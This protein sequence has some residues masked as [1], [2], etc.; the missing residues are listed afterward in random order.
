MS[1]SV[2]AEL[3]LGRRPIASAATQAV[4]VAP[5]GLRDLR[6]VARLQRRSFRPM[7]AYR[8]STLLLLWAWPRAT[9]LVARAGGRIVGCAIGDFQGGQSRVINICVDPDARR[10]RIGSRLL[11]AIET[12]LPR[13][14]MMLMVEQQ[15]EAAKRLYEHAGYRS[16]GTSVGYYGRGRDGVWMQK[17]RTRAPAPPSDPPTRSLGSLVS[18]SS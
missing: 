13:A 18:P 9:F 14:D 6:A 15:N 1:T 17:N 7:L 12:A 11:A 4:T 10:Q 8:L 2:D 3:L 16:V 5:V